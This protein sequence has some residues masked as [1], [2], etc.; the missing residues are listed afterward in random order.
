[1]SCAAL[2]AVQRTDRWQH[3]DT[4]HFG[5]PNLSDSRRPAFVAQYR[6]KTMV[7]ACREIGFDH[8]KF[9]CNDGESRTTKRLKLS[10]QQEK[11][12]VEG[13]GS[14]KAISASY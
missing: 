7:Q 5:G 11:A 3:A 4:P 6:P 2:F 1:V 10:Q 9:D 14:R 12:T 13:G 8:G